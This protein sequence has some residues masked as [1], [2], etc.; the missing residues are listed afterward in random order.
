MKAKEYLLYLGLPGLVSAASLLA[1]WF[2]IIFLIQGD[3]KVSVIC[4]VAAFGLDMLD[5]F[6]ARKLNKAT[7]IGRQLDGMID[8][9]N[10]SVYSA[11]LCWLVLM[12]GML[13]AWVGFFVLLSGALRLVRFNSEGYVEGAGVQYYRGVV[14]CHLSLAT[15]VLLLILQHIEIAQWFM[16]VILITLAAGQLSSIKTRKTGLIPVWVLLGILLIIGAIV[17]LP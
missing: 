16:A 15:V 5:G 3:L 4:A 17:W 2:A 6:T 1:A 13:G 10:Y 12:P 8:F 14:T 11:L 9:V 7:E